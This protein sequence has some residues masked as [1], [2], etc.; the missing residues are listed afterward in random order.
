[1][2][3]KVTTSYFLI[4]RVIFLKNVFGSWEDGSVGRV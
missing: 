1:M 3:E 2:R 4:G